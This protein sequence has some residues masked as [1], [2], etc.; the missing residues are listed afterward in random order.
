MMRAFFRRAVFLAAA[1]VGGALGVLWIAAV[2]AFAFGILA[3]SLVRLLLELPML[4]W[5]S[6]VGKD[7]R[8]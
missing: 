6:S 1:I 3:W 7:G 4:I 8:R 2:C 5:H